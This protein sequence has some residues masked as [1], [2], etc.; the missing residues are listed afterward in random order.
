MAETRISERLEAV[1][2]RIGSACTRFGRPVS[3]VKLLAVAKT[4]PVSM[5]EDAWRAGQ[6]HFAENYLQEGLNKIKAVSVENIQWH[7]IGA[8]QSNKTR[9]IAENYAYVHTVAS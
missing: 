8:I 9:A 2:S 5:I 1:R 3:E 7:Y 4:K 6:R